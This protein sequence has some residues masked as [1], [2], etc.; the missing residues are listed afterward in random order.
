MHSTSYS[1]FSVSWIYPVHMPFSLSEMPLL[2]PFIYQDFKRDSESFQGL[3]AECL[4]DA[5]ITLKTYWIFLSAYMSA[6]HNRLCG[7][8]FLVSF[9]H[10]LPPFLL[11]DFN[12]VHCGMCPY[13]NNFPA[14]LTARGVMHVNKFWSKKGKMKSHR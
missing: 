13:K 7:R 14:F 9:Q 10:L 1:T 5:T 2:Y 8:Q 12:P 4:L 3:Q 11:T 6:S